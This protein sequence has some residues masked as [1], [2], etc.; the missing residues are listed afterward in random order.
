MKGQVFTYLFTLFWLDKCGFT[1]FNYYYLT[2]S[3]G[4]YTYK[5]A[6]EKNFLFS[7]P[8]LLFSNLPFTFEFIESDSIN[9]VKMKL[10]RSM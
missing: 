8:Q 1:K 4:M 7:M 3:I 6:V 9:A 10:T 5:S 2:T